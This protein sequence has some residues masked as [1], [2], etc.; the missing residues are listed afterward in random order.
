MPGVT[1]S[2]RSSKIFL[3]QSEQSITWE[4]ARARFVDKTGRP[5]P[6]TWEVG[7]FPEG[8]DDYPVSGVSWY[9]A[10]AYCEFVGKTLPTAYHWNGAAE[11]LGTVAV[12]PLSNFSGKGPTPVGAYQGMTS[13]GVYDMAGNVR[14][15]CWNAGEPGDSRYILGGGWSDNLNFYTDALSQ[16]ALDRSPINGFRCMKPVSDGEVDAAWLEP[17]EL[18]VRDFAREDVVPDNVFA[19]L[20][21]DVCLRR[22]PAQRK[23]REDV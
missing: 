2:T 17:I 16:P 12:V 3:E 22:T 21:T 5:G 6:A 14:E 20:R 11:M 18:P 13:Y 19:D 7:D 1:R 9:E 15:W 23:G 4:D 8:Q 10:A